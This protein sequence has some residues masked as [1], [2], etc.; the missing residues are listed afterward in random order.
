MKLKRTHTIRALLL[1]YLGISAAVCIALPSHFPDGE[2]ASD[3]TVISSAPLDLPQDI[4]QRIEQDPDAGAGAPET[5]AEPETDVTAEPDDTLPQTS[6]ES[7]AEPQTAPETNQKPEAAP[8]TTQETETEAPP[9]NT[10]HVSTKQAG[11]RVNLRAAANSKAK[12]I[13][14]VYDEDEVTVLSE[15]GKWYEI[16]DGDITGYIHR[17]YLVLADE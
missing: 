14:V 13:A 3:K 1:V 12:I 16:Q 5:A 15:S 2:N 10:A 7:E 6:G 11:A 4:Q 17:D 9:E 8:E